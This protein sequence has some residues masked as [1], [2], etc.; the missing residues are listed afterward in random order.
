LLGQT[1]FILAIVFAVVGF[2]LRKRKTE[3]PVLVSVLAFFSALMSP[4]G[5]IFLMVLAFKKDLSSAS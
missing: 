1:I 2:Y 5:L 4:I 3:T